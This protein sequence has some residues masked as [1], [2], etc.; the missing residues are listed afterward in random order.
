MN[1]KHLLCITLLLSGCGAETDDGYAIGSLEWDRIEVA[2]QVAETVV[3]WEAQEGN[4]VTA[5]Q[6]LLRL[7]D[8][9]LQARVTAAGAARAQAAARLAELERGTRP[10]R[11]AQAQAQLTGSELTLQF[12]QRELARLSALLKRKLIAPDQVDAARIAVDTARANRD[13]A[14]AAL[15][16]QQQGATAEERDQIRQ[17]LAAAEAELRTAQLDSAFATV[18]APVAGRLDELPFKVGERPAI[19]SVVAVILAGTHP[20]A[21]VYVPEAVRVQIHPGSTARVNIDGLDMAFSG[22]VRKVAADASFTP[23]YALTEHD[24]GRLSYVAEIDIDANEH[25]ARVLPA[26]VPVQVQFNLAGASE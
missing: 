10:E 1:P 2:A 19:G 23:Y 18:T 4:L 13:A 14:R 5:G 22:S 8:D 7:N 16:E 17:A 6:P 3:A 20:Y 25:G 9:R 21:R 11:I 15:D 26:G 24:R 12:Q